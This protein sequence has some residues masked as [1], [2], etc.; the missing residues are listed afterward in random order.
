L[1]SAMVASSSIGAPTPLLQS[2]KR[3]VSAAT[4]T[5]PPP[6]T[7]DSRSYGIPPSFATPPPRT[8]VKSGTPHNCPHPHPCTTCSCTV[9]NLFTSFLHWAHGAE[10]FS[11]ECEK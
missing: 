11:C 6:T 5:V 1:S 7:V 9:S 8:P 4:Q 3:M 10:W 2:P